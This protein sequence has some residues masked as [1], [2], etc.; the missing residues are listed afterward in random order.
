M[1]LAVITPPVGMNPFALK[2]IIAE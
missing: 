2:T 1:A